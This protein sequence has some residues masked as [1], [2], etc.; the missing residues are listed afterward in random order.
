[1]KFSIF[2]KA[3]F[4]TVFSG[5]IISTSSFAKS[6]ECE[7][8]S[9]DFNQ[10]HW[11][12]YGEWFPEK[13]EINVNDFKTQPGRESIS[14][15]AQMQF[16]HSGEFITR[17]LRLL[18]NGKL[19]GTT[20]MKS[21]KARY[22]CNMK[23]QE[24]LIAQKAEEE[25]KRIAELKAKKKNEEIAK[26][27]G[28]LELKLKAEEKAK[29]IAV[30]KAKEE[31]KQIAALKAEKRK[32]QKLE[33]ELAALK[34]KKAKQQAVMQESSSGAV[35]LINSPEQSTVSVSASSAK[36]RNAKSPQEAQAFANNIQASIVMFRAIADVIEKQPASL[37]DRVLGVVD[38]EITR[39]RAEKE[40]LQKQLS[41]RFSTPIKPSNANLAVSAFRAA[42]TFPKI[43][44]YVPG[45]NEIGEMLVVPRVTDDGFLNYK[46][47]FLDPAATY[48][49]V[50]DSISIPH[51][52]V[53]SVITGLQ[54][55]DEWTRVA[56]ENNINR[57]VEKSAACIPEGKCENKK[58]G[59]S[60]TEVM[61]QIYEDGSTAGRIQRNKGK[62][63]VGYNMSVE[64]SIL[65]SA[66]LT[67]MRDVGAKE[68][69]IGVMSDNEVK[70]LFN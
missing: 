55:V 27:I 36:W 25:E 28:A 57:R 47:D 42:D 14:F 50:R 32:A 39:L 12:D 21:G 60:S 63:S 54:K 68:F 3:I 33:Q 16:K 45:T 35:T 67:Y 19:F 58:Q 17:E 46:F 9:K 70:K 61:F 34:A 44:F 64:S 56:Q 53:D 51:K 52:S 4:V 20:P 23:P 13:L 29:Q 22:N 41:S 66:Y 26:R 49:K 5:L 62:F 38:S 59:I 15:R 69:N 6:I 8:Y 48:D 1:M 31:A 40:L 7:R 24:V 2:A 10:S 30:A 18:P 11:S 37:K 43:P 65:L